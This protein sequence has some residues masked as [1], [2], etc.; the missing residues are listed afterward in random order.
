VVAVVAVIVAVARAASQLALHRRQRQAACFWQRQIFPGA[1]RVLVAFWPSGA[2]LAL[3][4]AHLLLSVCTAAAVCRRTS[5][6]SPSLH[7][8]RAP[9]L[10]TDGAPH[11]NR[12]VALACTEARLPLASTQ[13]APLIASGA[14]ARTR[15]I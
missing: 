1:L 8:W 13:S 15:P 12:G 11:S 10:C 4:L 5:R 14:C 7:S 6:C 3:K 9:V 2:A